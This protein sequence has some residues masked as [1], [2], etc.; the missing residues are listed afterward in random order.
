MSEHQWSGWPGAYCLKCGAGDPAEECMADNCDGCLK[1]ADCGAYLPNTTCEEAGHKF[2]MPCPK[3]PQTSC[4]V[5]DKT[6]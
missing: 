6:S 5:P 1:C 2:L 3:H 4:P